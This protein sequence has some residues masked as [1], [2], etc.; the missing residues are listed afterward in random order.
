VSGCWRCCRPQ[1]GPTGQSQGRRVAGGDTS[2]PFPLRKPHQKVLMHKKSVPGAKERPV[3]RSCEYFWRHEACEPSILAVA[4]L[5]QPAAGSARGLTA[6]P[7][8][9]Q[10]DL[11]ARPSFPPAP[12]FAPLKPLSSPCSTSS[13][14]WRP[15]S[16]ARTWAASTSSPRAR[17]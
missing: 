16:P 7:L 8:L 12:Q 14:P 17:R 2:Q 13:S 1:W 11:T 15:P 9:S 6:R 3:G 5:R 10:P 4:Q